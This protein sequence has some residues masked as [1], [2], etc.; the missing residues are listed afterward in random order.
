METLVLRARLRSRRA[1]HSARSL[2]KGM[3][4][5]RVRHAQHLQQ[6][7]SFASPTQAPSKKQK[8]RRSNVNTCGSALL[9]SYIYVEPRQIIGHTK[10]QYLAALAAS[11]RH[12]TIKEKTVEGQSVHSAKLTRQGHGRRVRHSRYSRSE[13]LQA[14]QPPAAHTTGWYQRQPCRRRMSERWRTATEQPKQH[15]RGAHLHPSAP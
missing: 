12:C 5:N 4:Q 15:E 2:G 6:L 3:Q 7:G 8:K 1:A 9:R 11:L 10:L 13:C 14:R